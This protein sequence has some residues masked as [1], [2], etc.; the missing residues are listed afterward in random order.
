MNKPR[1]DSSREGNRSS[2]VNRLSDELLFRYMDGQLSE[3]EAAEVQGKINRDPQAFKL[4]TTLLRLKATEPSEQELADFAQEHA[5]TPAAE[6]VKKLNLRKTAPAFPDSPVSFVDQIITVIKG[7][8]KIVYVVPVL[9]IAVFLGRDLFLPEGTSPSDK[10]TFDT[11]L[12]L[13]E[14]PSILRS[15]DKD[16]E[17]FVSGL[18]NGVF[19][20][21][22]LQYASAVASFESIENDVEA[23][24]LKSP[25]PGSQEFD[26]L[27]DYYLYKGL[28]RLALST[29]KKQK[30]SPTEKSSQL[31]L[32]VADLQ[33]CVTL[34]REAG[35]EK[36]E[37]EYY[38][39]ALAQALSSKTD[40]AKI[41]LENIPADGQ[42]SKEAQ[43][44]RADF[45][46]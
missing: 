23:L 15:T 9:L 18:D 5:F 25:E 35:L 29:S 11:V 40:D 7:L 42:Y 22:S 30:L 27:R 39:L 19:Q 28:S 4:Y 38:F 6:V 43:A 31:N 1:K 46:F 33:Q 16:V 37:R 14:F 45:N 13:D 24:A 32:A 12:P 44:L 34:V 2:G 36:I 20:Y 17:V 8:P 41:S 10:Y 26:W 21:G 3:E